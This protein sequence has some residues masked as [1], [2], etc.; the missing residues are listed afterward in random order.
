LGALAAVRSRLALPCAQ[1]RPQ[2]VAAACSP[3]ADGF[4]RAEAE[5]RALF[6]LVI[7]AMLVLP[8]SGSLPPGG[9]FVSLDEVNRW[10]ANYRVQPQPDRLPAAVRALARLG[11]LKEA[12][13]A[14]VYVGFIAG[15]IGAN[16]DKAEDL[17]QRMLAATDTEQ[18]AI[19][20]AIAYSGHP[21]WKLWLHKFAERMPARKVMIDKYLEGGLQKLE[22]VPLERRAPT[23]WEKLRSGLGWESERPALEITFEKSPEL[24]DTLWGYYFGTGSARPIGRII[25]LLPWANDHDSVDKLTIGNM[26]KYTLASNASRDGELLAMLKRAHKRQTGKIASVLDEVIFA[27]ETMET[28]LLRKQALAAIEELKRKGPGYKRDISTWGQIGQGALALGCIVAATTGHVEL[29]LPC[30]IGGA[31]SGAALSVWSGQ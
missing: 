6:A 10:M 12:E 7:S 19:V 26:A 9:D 15:V 2:K 16:P 24:L 5:M 20:R 4:G 23:L 31:A 8:A 1:R 30:I 13:G 14:G 17:I 11:A 25:A 29:G 3:S 22:N 28:A 21:D 18:W 27:A